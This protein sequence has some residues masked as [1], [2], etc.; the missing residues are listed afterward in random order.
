M[1]PILYY[2][3]GGFRHILNDKITEAAL[4]PH[5]GKGGM[6]VPLNSSHNGHFVGRKTSRN[7]CDLQLF[8]KPDCGEASPPPGGIIVNL[9]SNLYINQVRGRIRDACTLQEVQLLASKIY[10]SGSA[11]PGRKQNDGKN[12]CGRNSTGRLFRQ[13]SWGGGVQRNCFLLGNWG[14]GGDPRQCCSR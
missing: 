13:G 9:W 11:R 12:E 2:V 4:F 7:H 8:R 6:P 10:R 5:A 3:T 14:G 1:L